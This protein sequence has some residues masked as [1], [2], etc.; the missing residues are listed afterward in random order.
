MGEAKNTVPPNTW[1]GTRPGIIITANLLPSMLRAGMHGNVRGAGCWCIRWILGLVR[2]VPHRRNL[3]EQEL[4]GVV[5]VGEILHCL[6][7]KE[8]TK[9]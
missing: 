9:S 5:G 4:E 2:C 7:E 3:P 6:E 1:S 8:K